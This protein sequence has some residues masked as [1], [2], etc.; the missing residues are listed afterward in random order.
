VVGQIH[1]DDS[2]SS[3]PVCELHYNQAGKLSMGVERT[4]DGGDEK[5]TDVGLWL[6][7][8]RLSMGFGKRECS[9]C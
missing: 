2:I 4:R 8:R 7:E 9:Q 6:W 5:F 1:I 3:K